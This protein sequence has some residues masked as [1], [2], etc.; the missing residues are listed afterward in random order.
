MY[1]L[2]FSDPMKYE[3]HLKPIWGRR[4]FVS[5]LCSIIIRI[6]LPTIMSTKIGYLFIY[7]RRI[8]RLLDSDCFY[9]VYHNLEVK[10]F[11]YSVIVLQYVFFLVLNQHLILVLIERRT[12]IEL[13][14]LFTIFVLSSLIYFDLFLV[15]YYQHGT[16]V[17]L[18]QIE[19]DLH[20]YGPFKGVVA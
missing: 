2:F 9:Q 14:N 12:L 16:K 18:G 11:F 3:M 10:P 6:V 17:L 19:A 5:H 15:H 1:A 13:I 8:M 4:K 7:G 20:A